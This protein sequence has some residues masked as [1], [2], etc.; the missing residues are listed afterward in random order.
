VPK[1]E[2]QTQVIEYT[3]FETLI[4]KIKESGT[5]TQKTLILAIETYM[6]KMKPGMPVDDAT[7]ARNQYV[8]WKTISGLVERAEKDEFKKLWSIL[9]GYFDQYKDGAFHD[10]YVFRFSEFWHYSISELNAYQRVINLI[11]LTANAKERESGLK[12]VDLER[13]LAEG[14]SEEAR[15]RIITFYK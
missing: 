3:E 5:A 7:G 1:V 9:L 12:Q 14:F 10:R 4:N 13:T 6:E 15:Q 8:F 2:E 11:K